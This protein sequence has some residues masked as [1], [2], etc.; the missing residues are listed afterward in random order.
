[1]TPAVVQL[2][3]K[4]VDYRL[5]EYVHD[6]A[7]PSYGEEAVAKL[8]LDP[9]RVF[10]TLVLSPDG[11]QLFVA[12]VPVAEKVDLKKM[13]KAVAVKKI[14]MAEKA[15]VERATG[16]VLG[17]V[18]PVAQKKRLKTVVDG[19]AQQFD[20]IFVSAGRRGLEI[21]LSPTDLQTLTQATF[22]DI[23]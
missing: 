21:E 15:A 11:K 8:G 16:Y 1:M 14:A 4:R 3:K 19:S 17:G 2:D 13:A 7:S 12:V 10:K 5:H 23:S 18:S 22:A 9:K 6:D 20:T